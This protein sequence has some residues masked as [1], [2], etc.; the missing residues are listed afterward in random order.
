MRTRNDILAD[1]VRENYPKIESSMD[2]ALYRTCETV[3]ET[4]SFISQSFRNMFIPKENLMTKTNTKA[5]IDINDVQSE[6]VIDEACN[7]I[8]IEDLKRDWNMYMEEDRGCWYTT[9]IERIEI[10]AEDLIQRELERIHE[11]GD[12]YEDFD[13]FAFSSIT[14]KQFTKLQEII[15]EICNDCAFEV[16]RQDKPID[17]YSEVGR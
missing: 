16:F 8:P 6:F 14:K 9:T 4:F 5:L 12:A 3:K 7:V 10:D 11:S 13:D 1:Y 2:F 17:P 15:N